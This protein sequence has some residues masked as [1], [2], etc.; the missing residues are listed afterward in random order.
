MFAM[1]GRI[2]KDSSYT[3]RFIEDHIR[4]LTRFNPCT[5]RES[6]SQRTTAV[7]L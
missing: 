2:E 5:V 6:V 4:L 7:L 3:T 1:F